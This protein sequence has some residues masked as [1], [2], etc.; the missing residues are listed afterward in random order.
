MILINF[1]DS[2]V[3]TDFLDPFGW[4]GEAQRTC[5]QQS[6]MQS[7][8][9]INR[10]H[11]SDVRIVDNYNPW[12][13]ISLHLYTEWTYLSFTFHWFQLPITMPSRI[14]FTSWP[15]SLVL[16]NVDREHSNDTYMTGPDNKTVPWQLCMLAHRSRGFPSCP[17]ISNTNTT[18]QP[19]Q[20][21]APRR[22]W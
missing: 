22:F 16:T 7:T 6:E 8:H 18:T 20:Y 11:T 3:F 12:I 17:G 2:C 13:I 9:C 14:Y 21:L 4:F 5:A 15:N 1:A 19:R 10:C